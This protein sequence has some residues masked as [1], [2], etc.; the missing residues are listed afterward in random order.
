MN[1]KEYKFLFGIM[2]L[3]LLI[4]CILTRGEYIYGSVTDWVTQHYRIPEYFRNLFYETHDLFP[5]FAFNLGAGQNIYYLSYYGLLS[6]IILLSYLFPF[7]SMQ[8]YIILS[9][10]L[11]LLISIL[12]FYYWIHKRYDTK[13][14]LVLTLLFAFA[15]PLLF[16]SHRHIMFMNYM[17]FL[18]MGFIGV[19]AYFDKK[20]I[21]LLLFGIFF[22]IMTSY[23]FSVSG[24][25]A[26][27]IYGIYKYME[28][29][30]ERTIKSYI[31]DG[32][33]FACPFIIAICMAGV[34]LL[35]TLYTILEGRV[36]GT[37]PTLLSLLLPTFKLTDIL[38]GGYAFGL[39]SVLFLAI[40]YNMNAKEVKNRFLAV[41]LAL[42]VSFPL[43]L[44]ILNGGMYING[45]VLIPFIPLAL[46]CISQLFVVDKIPKNYLYMYG[47]LSLVII[48]LS[49]KNSMV[50]LYIVDVVI[51]IV[52][53]Y[54]LNKKQ[55]RKVFTWLMLVL[56]F[57][58]SIYS[59]F[60]DTLVKK[61]DIKSQFK[62]D[63][64]EE[65]NTVYRTNNL[66]NHLYGIN[67]VLDSKFYT[68]SIYSST[69][70]PNYKNFYN[71]DINNEF[72]Y[73]SREILATPYNVLSNIYL[74]N[75]YILA[76]NYN[77]VGYKEVK[78]GVPNIYQNDSVFSIG[79]AT[80]SIMSTREYNALSYP[81]NVDALLHYTV[82]D[83]DKEDVYNQKIEPIDLDVSIVKNDMELTKT[84]DGYT[85]D[86]LKDDS[87]LTLHIN[88]LEQLHNKILLLQFTI[89]N[90]SNRDRSIAINGI[91]NKLTKKGWKYHNE[92]STFEYTIGE[93][94]IDTLDIVFSK[95]KF[96]ITNI[97]CYTFE[98][99]DILSIQNETHDSLLIDK[100]KTKGDVIEGV[101]DVTENGYFSISI[102]YDKGFTIY[103]DENE[104]SYE[105]VND[106][107]IGFEISKG[108]HSIK[109]RY[110]SP[111]KKIGIIISIVGFILCVLILK[112]NA[113]KRI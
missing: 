101:I 37:S 32:L 50:A 70:N 93:E 87:H 54:F 90:T 47:V 33:A 55:N 56:V 76:E 66:Y 21:G 73:R 86:S 75:K 62:I 82:V 48:Y 13:L 51:T 29:A 22:M 6:P 23:F 103:V 24:M 26:L 112:K 40:I 53:V 36:E 78:S 43:S 57:S 20:K 104:V 28:V 4:I 16:H 96:E 30:K 81:Y 110:Q 58:S 80:K 88:N 52:G 25:I 7:I 59:N 10:I 27:A 68:T 41:V 8:N 105:R 60:N 97:E 74:G 79:Y 5:D 107:F 34:L 31:K 91:R 111:C 67:H 89:E 49:H 42:L 14:S 109:I 100:E 77:Q 94:D 3:V 108:V 46:L 2:G 99:K 1:K 63:Y 15:T 12:L 72:T 102:P 38:Y 11:C 39:T 35:P 95:G 69:S 19:D 84:N 83:I 98:R 92:N 65:K 17:P 9:T 85:V 106:N 18:M 71:N 44:Y 64:I 61:N 45:K 113:N